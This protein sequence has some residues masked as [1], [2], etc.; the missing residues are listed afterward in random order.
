MD[1][2]VVGRDDELATL[3]T[4]LDEV[5]RLPRALLLD[6]EA[7]IGKTTLWRAGIAMGRGRGFTV[8]ASSPSAA[9]SQLA[10]AALADLLGDVFDDA[11]AHLP[12]PQRDAL[13]VA[14]LRAD[15]L[16]GSADPRGVA[17]AFLGALRRLAD[18]APL[19]VCVDDVQWLDVSSASSLAFAVRRLEDERIGLLIARRT[20]GREQPP[21]LE[22]SRAP[23]AP[24]G[25]D[26]LGI[27]ALS[28]GA[29][30][31]LLRT[32]LGTTFTRPTLRRIRDASGGNPF[33]ALE[34]GRALQARGAR[35]ASGESLPIPA[36]L[37]A[38][39]HERIAA[40]PAR[41]RELLAVVA[42]LAQP[43]PD[44]VQAA[45]DDGDVWADLRPAFDAHVLELDGS[46]IRFTHPLLAAAAESELSPSDRRS[47]HSR[48]AG[49][50]RDVE[51]RARH[52]ALSAD[53]AD[54]RAANALENA[55]RTAAQ[56]GAPAAAAELAQLA[57]ELTPRDHVTDRRRRLMAAGEQ[58][59]IAGENRK[60]EEAFE[61]CLAET[62]SGHERAELLF[63]L[64][65]ARGE[66][67]AKAGLDLKEKAL[68]EPALDDRLRASILLLRCEERVMGLELA[69]AAKDA[70][71]AL[72]TVERLGDEE[73]LLPALVHVPWTDLWRGH[74]LDRKQLERGL[75]MEGRFP[76]TEGYWT[77][78]TVLG[79]GLVFLDRLDEARPVLLAEYDRGRETHALE[80]ARSAFYLAEL[81]LRAGNWE[82]AAQFAAEALTLVEQMGAKTNVGRYLY[83][84]AM[85]DAHVG[86]VDDARAAV[87]AGLALTPD[88]HE[89]T[90][91]RH[92]T[93]LGFV[94]TT[95]R[96]YERA[97]EHIGS[98]AQIL[99]DRGVREPGIFL[100]EADELEARAALKQFDVAAARVDAI[101][102]RARELDRPREF[103]YAHRG[104]GLLAAERGDLEGARDCLEHALAEHE[105]LGVP[106]E[107]ARTMLAL[108]QIE[109][110]G[111]RKRPAR[112]ALDEALHIFD[113]LG[114]RL[115]ADRA[116][117]ELARVGGRRPAGAELTATERRIAELVAEGRSNKEV[118][119]TLFVTVK[120][121]ERNLT[122]I[123]EKL[124]VRS[125]AEL[126]RRG[127]GGAATRVNH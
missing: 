53:G 68:Q 126:A 41:T 24:E 95:L 7:G 10:Y 32:R 81:E 40:L 107:R 102:R 20:E 56:R 78:T 108:G 76:N 1:Q 16:T 71:E 97:L 88:V 33:Y 15:P 61:Q 23:F 103:V 30:H 75:A 14:L 80:R 94:E 85:V 110:R 54:A 18:A 34:I 79:A 65:V 118:A 5:D 43:T 12:H 87:E 38:L 100:F 73:L 11:V 52:L 77:A 58:F 44:L 8:L 106:F 49:T 74:G 112:D 13:A 4:F 98:M 111:K 62:P 25:L 72:A 39:V 124:G 3:G 114:A 6:G 113:E 82:D 21:P 66:D 9:E 117:A 115:W 99:A 59:F 51:E 93:V 91:L 48:L 31:H 28:V 67:D 119:S 57:V 29:L 69:G 26:R 63:R 42:A 96:R 27:G 46:S 105:R 17:F 70:R 36:S 92:R 120:T 122:R 109:R 127:L 37:R 50:V 22:L 19:L 101:E 2:Q 47:L 89:S 90:T 35:I 45:A 123:Y 60:S 64:S 116:R 104:R 55:A 86:H 121:V 125:R 84:R 83:C